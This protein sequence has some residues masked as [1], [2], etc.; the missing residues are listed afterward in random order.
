[1]SDNYSNLHQLT[2]K[3]IS[4]G[5]T[6]RLDLISTARETAEASK[7][8]FRTP[9]FDNHFLLS[10]LAT[11]SKNKSNTKAGIWHIEAICRNTLVAIY[12]LYLEN[13]GQGHSVKLSQWFHSMA[14]IEIYEIRIRHFWTRSHYFQDISI[15]NI[16]PWKSESR[17]YFRNGTIRWQ[18]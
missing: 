8:A 2:E 10:L 11:W 3:C 13:V 17:C 15:W 4:W 5:S 6:R 12:N 9:I 16:W 14:I 1:M 18:I 7:R